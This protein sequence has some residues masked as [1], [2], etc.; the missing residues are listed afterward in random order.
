MKFIELENG[1]KFLV[2]S[3]HELDGENYMFLAG[4]SENPVYLFVKVLEGDEVEPVNDEELLKRLS[5]LAAK[6][7]EKMF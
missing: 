7:A 3:K 1:K 6:D 4:V 2:L 5:F